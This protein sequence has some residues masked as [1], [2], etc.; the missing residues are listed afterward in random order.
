MATR[1][2][3]PCQLEHTVS[4][5]MWPPKSFN[6]LKSQG[7][8]YVNFLSVYRMLVRMGLDKQAMV[9]MDQIAEIEHE[10]PE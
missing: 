8:Y 6:Y 4:I 3:K 9:F 1:K 7:K 2:N 10:K 5:P